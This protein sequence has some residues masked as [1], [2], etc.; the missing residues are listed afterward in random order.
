[1]NELELLKNK[2]ASESEITNES[3]IKDYINADLKSQTKKKMV[4]G[5]NYYKAQH[6]ILDHDFR[7]YYVNG[8]KYIDENK[9]NNRVVNPF[10]RLLVQQ[11]IGYIV[12]QPMALSAEDK[13]HEELIKEVLGEKFNDTVV[14]WVKGASNKSREW[15]HPF[16][17]EVGEFDYIIIPAEQIIPIYDTSY[18]KRLINI[19]RYY[20]MEV[21]RDGK[22]VTRYKVELWDSEKVTFYIEDDNGNYVLDDTEEINPS[23]HWY[24]YNTNNPN[25]IKANSWGKVPFISLDNNSELISDLEPIKTYIDAYDKISSGYIND[26]EDIQ[27]AIWI[28]KGYEDENLSQFMKNLIT[29]KAIKVEG[30]GD[31]DNKTLEIPIEA[32]KVMLDI[33][34]D[35][36]YEIGQGVKMSTDKFG[37]NPS[38]VALKFLYSGLDLKANTMIRKLKKALQEFMWFITEYINRKNKTNYDHKTVK[39]TINKTMITNETEQI[40]NVQKSKGIISDK[41]A[42][43]NH[44]WVDDVEYEYEQMQKENTAYQLDNIPFEGVGDE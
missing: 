13:K 22:T 15:L 35:K 40:D 21:V 32:K 31:V 26:L 27:L 20:T 30:E 24:S 1:M 3:V 16:I 11:K 9:A 42:M 18:Q 8:E 7:V 6:D 10:H 33:L 19:I 23:Y 12:G 37:Q 38:G 25:D 17:N 4:E 2:I 44:P 36:I 34:E 41:T 14:E 29:F 39:F 5:V 28:L 43:A